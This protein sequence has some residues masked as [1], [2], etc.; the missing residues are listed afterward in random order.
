VRLTAISN[1]PKQTIS[2]SN[3]LEL[4]QIVSEPNTEQCVNEDV[5]FPRGV[6]CEILHRLERGMKHSL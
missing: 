3:G 5:G 6:D 2:A 1:G 4:L